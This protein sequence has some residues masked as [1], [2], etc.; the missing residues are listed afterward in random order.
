MEI[1]FRKYKADYDVVLIDQ[2]SGFYTVH[3]AHGDEIDL[4]NKVYD[5]L[6]DAIKAFEER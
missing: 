4:T 2:G 5:N 6:Q 1:L 3:T